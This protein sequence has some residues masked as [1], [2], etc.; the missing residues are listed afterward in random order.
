MKKKYL[1]GVLLSVIVI[2]SDGKSDFAN[3]QSCPP[4]RPF[5]CSKFDCVANLDECN[6]TDDLQTEFDDVNAALKAFSKSSKGARS[7][8]KKF[9]K[10]ISAVSLDLSMSSCQDA[11]SSDLDQLESIFTDVNQKACTN[12][13]K[14][15]FF[16]TRNCIPG[17]AVLDFQNAVDKFKTDVTSALPGACRG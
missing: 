9:S 8:A 2:L 11:V 10:A 17:Q 12:P 4:E 13:S 5:L 14:R 16:K 15:L 1:L 6:P 3:A 7:F